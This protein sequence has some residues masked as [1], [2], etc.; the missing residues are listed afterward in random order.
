MAQGIDQVF[1]DTLLSG[2]VA[3][4]RRSLAR[5]ITIIEDMSPNGLER[6]YQ[7][8]AQLPAADPSSVIMAITGPPGV[9][10]S[11]FIEQMGLHAIRAGYR[12]GVLSIDPSS[13]RTGGSIL[14][15]QMRMPELSRHEDA[16]IRPSPS[17]GV[18]GGIGHRTWE[19]SRL[20]AATGFSLI[21]IETVGVGQSE[22]EVRHLADVVSVLLQPGSGDDTQQIKM[23]LNEIADI[24]IINKADDVQRQLAE[25]LKVQIKSA[26]KLSHT[27]QG[28]PV[29]LNSQFDEVLNRSCWTQLHNLIIQAKQHRDS[30]HILPI[31]QDY[32]MKKRG[33]ELLLQ[34]AKDKVNFHELIHRFRLDE[35]NHGSFEMTVMAFLDQIKKDLG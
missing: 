26:I 35:N 9:G 10:K 1:L 13:Q 14:G 8:L 27:K 32:W 20:L 3:G 19:V 4:D 16:F 12:V 7:L 18:L 15:D 21:F 33:E 23:G 31:R 5:A 28:I 17:Q 29:V 2:I 6:A 25:Q 24:F 30:H 11:S 22:L 34:L